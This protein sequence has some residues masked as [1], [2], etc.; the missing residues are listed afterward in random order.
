MRFQ[1]L[2]VILSLAIAP[3][4]FAASSTTHELTGGAGAN[5][6]IPT[7]TGGNMTFTLGAG[8]NYQ[9]MDMLQL[10]GTLGFSTTSGATAIQAL[11]GPT[12]NF[13]AS[14]LMN[15]IYVA[16]QVGINY[17]NTTASSTD[18]AYKG[19]VGKR[20]PIVGSVT[21]KPEANISGTTATGSNPEINVVPAQF[22]FFF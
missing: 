21:W 6:N 2:A 20:F 18:F 12:M 10:G 7:A 11:V 4:A 19:A 22:A 1:T 9:F 15:S 8:Y 3:A 13:G 16:A 5:L 14:D 17:V